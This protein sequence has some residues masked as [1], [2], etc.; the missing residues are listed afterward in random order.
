MLVF[1]GNDDEKAGLTATPE[2]RSGWQQ[3][4]VKC[5]SHKDELV[6]GI[7]RARLALLVC[8]CCCLRR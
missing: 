7:G 1:A 2:L 8:I 3:Y 5:I 6:T 4:D